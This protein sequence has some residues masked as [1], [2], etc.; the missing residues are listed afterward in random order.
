MSASYSE[1]LPLT[2]PTSLSLAALN[3]CLPKTWVHCCLVSLAPMA[4]RHEIEL[5]QPFGRKKRIEKWPKPLDTRPTT[6][7]A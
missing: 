1:K 3:M 4:Q 6:G 5:V 7:A 2:E